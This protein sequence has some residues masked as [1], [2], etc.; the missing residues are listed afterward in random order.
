MHNT[1]IQMKSYF[2]SFIKNFWFLILIFSLNSMLAQET[3]SV[4][5]NKIRTVVIDAGHGGND[6]GAVGDNVFEKDIALEIALKL[7]KYIEEKF[8]DVNVIYTRTTDVRVDLHRR[9]AIANENNA[10]LFI[11]IH[12][13]SID[14]PSP[15]GTET[16]V[17][18][19]HRAGESFD[20]AIRENSVILYE[21]DHSVRYSN[22][23]PTSPESYI[24]FSLMRNIYDEQSV[25]FATFVQDQFRER[26]MRKD[27]GVK[28]QGL[29]VLA[30][31]SMPGVLI[32]TGFISNPAEEKYLMSE[33]GQDFIASAIF[34][35]FRDYKNEIE[36]TVLPPETPQTASSV[37]P[38]PE[39]SIPETEETDPQTAEPQQLP[40][41][42]NFDPAKPVYFKVQI[43]AT[44]DEI[45]LESTYFEEFNDIE[46]FQSGGSYKYAVGYKLSYEEILEFSKMVRN[47]YPGAFIIAV[48]NGSIV[49]IQTA[50]DY[51]KTTL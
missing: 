3:S 7:G 50:R 4:D 28:R 33:D 13:N 5:D 30:D 44:S 31:L 40:E 21:E 49:P 22:F 8:P 48:H 17:L 23:D 32:E 35:A 15:Y 9:A 12:T 10:D 16:L 18:G 42:V 27:R 34:R 25:N 26:A 14:N 20:A 36:S 37:E 51:L 39:I 47:R 43:L 6:S 38:E 19:L 45:D 24:M 46:V 1:Q 41:P 11:S 29:L 2:T